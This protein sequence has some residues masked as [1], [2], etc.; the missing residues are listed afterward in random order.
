MGFQTQG[1]FCVECMHVRVV[2]YGD[3]TCAVTAKETCVCALTVV[4]SVNSLK[5]F[6][7]L[8]LLCYR[9]PTLM[10]SGYNALAISM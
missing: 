10:Q 1:T 4:H 6:R 3:T 2:E 5:G 8:V 7:L 9:N